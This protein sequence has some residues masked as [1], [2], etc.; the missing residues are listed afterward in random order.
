MERSPKKNE[1][2][3]PLPSDTTKLE[4]GPSTV[5]PSLLY[6]QN[7]ISLPT[8][9]GIKKKN[10]DQFTSSQIKEN[11][12]DGRKI[13]LDFTRKLGVLKDN[14]V[15]DGKIS[16]T[17]KMC[18]KLLLQI[19]IFIEFHISEGEREALCCKYSE[20]F[21][22]IAVGSADGVIQLYRSATG[23]LVS[24]LTNSDVKDNRAPVTCIKHRP[25]SKIYPI[26]NCYTS[27]YANGCIKCW[28]Y[29]FNQ[30]LYTIKEKRQTFGLTY[31]PRF[32]K[33][34]SFGDDLKV[35]F[36]DEET[37]T[38]ERVLSASYKADVHDGPM[39][40]IFAACFHPKN[41][42]ELITAGWDNV[43][44]FWDLRQPHAIRHISGVHM[45]GEG[46]DINQKGTEVLTCS[47]QKQDA[48]QVFDYGTGKRICSL[49]PDIYN[50]KLYCGKYATKDFVVCAGSD[51]N[52]IRVVDLQTTAVS[53]C[54]N[55]EF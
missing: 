31:H 35:Y 26:T 40:R 5:T 18:V 45:C 22:Y 9:A 29:H 43:V 14:V 27:T 47:W 19:D 55:S 54:F 42:Y 23:E 49:E 8:S 10:L 39:S 33:F 1:H 12:N 28:S 2:R 50:S 25:V 4:H 17:S 52:L 32:P 53:L 11:D 30:C 51:P 13:N 48:L 21:N 44:Q 36:Y 34:A 3:P 20:E 7:A 37:K 6:P 46:L 24:T 38:Q 41:N 16:I 15:I